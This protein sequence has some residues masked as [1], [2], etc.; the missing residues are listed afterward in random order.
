MKKNKFFLIGLGIILLF[1]FLLRIVPVLGNNFYFTMDQGND[2]VHVREILERHQILLVGPET[3]I[4]GL[5]AGP[6]WYYFI[7]IGYAIFGGHPAGAVFMLILLNTALTGILMWK[8]RKEVSNTWALLVGASLQT[9]WWFY[10]T[11]RYGFNPFPLVFLSFIL[12]LLLVDFIGGSKKSYLLAAIFVGLGFNTEIAGSMALAIFYFLIGTWS[13]FKRRMPWKNLIFGALILGI[14]LIPHV[15]TEIT[16]RFSQTQTLIKEFGDSS[17]V[18]SERN[19]D[20]LTPYFLKVISRSILRQIPE[21]GVLI[22]TLIVL[23]ASKKWQTKK[24]INKF[25]KRFVILSIVLILVSWF[26][27]GSNK[28]WQ[29]WH[30]VYI[31]PLIFVSTLLLLH[32][33]KKEIALPILILS[34]VFHTL[35]FKDRYL[36]YLKPTND[37]SIMSN[38]LKAIDWT[39]E[40]AA[41]QGF[42]AYIYLPSVYDYPYQYLFWWYGRGKYGYLP[43]EYSSFPGSPGIFIPGKK[44]YQQPQRSC[45]NLRFLIIEPDENIFLQHQWLDQLRQ[46]TQLVEETMVGKI[47]IEKR[48]ILSKEQEVP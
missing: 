4:Q 27:F 33:F 6:L 5:F 10:D 48:L 43:C 36:E 11:S 19:F 2:A 21:I 13:V 8:V 45:S 9:S 26:W 40:K 28:G 15:V 7:S 3:G 24:K 20:T 32:E 17:G 37:P 34:L 30:T 35:I 23:L 41:G 46:D 1:A 16:S 12:I 38:E 25:V 18:F 14:F 39:Y 44:Y 42:Y 29:D 47:K 22:F 31:S